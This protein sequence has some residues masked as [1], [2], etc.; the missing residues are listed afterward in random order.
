M[1]HKDSI[2][3]RL[4]RAAEAKNALLAKFKQ[5]ADPDNPEAIE[6]R[7]QREALVAAREERMAQRKIAQQ[8]HERE[9]AKQA[10]LEAEAAAEA[11]RAA[12]EQAAREA[13]EQSERQAA[14]EVEQKAARD[15][16]YAARKAAKKQRRRGY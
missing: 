10:A 9:L 7:R 15:A 1:S 16:R 12:A 5:A 11:A 4:N 6:K 13:A 3:D 2:Q 14:L 8:E